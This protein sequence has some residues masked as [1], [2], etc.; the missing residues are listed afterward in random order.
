MI[1][2]SVIAAVAAKQ[3]E[4]VL[5]RAGGLP[6][7]EKLRAAPAGFAWIISGVRR[8]GKSTLMEQFL[9]QAPDEA[10]YLNLESTALAG[11][12]LEDAGRLD[13]AI[14]ATGAKTIYLDE[15]QTLAGWE[16]YV[17]TKLDEGFR[18]VAT[19]S[20]ASL[21]GRELGTKLTGRHV[22]TELFPFDYGEFL[23]FT[24]RTPGADATRA[25][26]AAGGFPSYLATDDERILETLFADILERDVALRHAV[27]DIAGLRRLAAWLVEN[28]GG[29]M[30]AQ[31]LRQPLGVASASTLLQWAEHLADAYLFS[32]LPKFSPSLR[33]QLVNPRKI[34]CIDTGLQCALSATNAPDESR[35]F[36]NL[37]FL[38]L[39]RRFRDL[40]YF[41]GDGR[42][43]DFVAVAG[44]RPLDPVQATVALNEDSEE[45]EV[46]GMR[47]AMAA[48]GR[49]RGWIVTVGEE[50]VLSVP[51]GEIRIVPFHAF[52]PAAI[53]EAAPVAKRENGSGT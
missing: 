28:A 3:K 1:R 48:L 45:R 43:C 4:H 11:L 12:S 18:V 46:T 9:R 26:L 29:K 24:E 41:E 33:V 36:E 31:R 27:R 22:D 15:V 8:C 53:G 32:F 10:F 23:A 16:R 37:V 17:R 21:L 7:L 25:Y 19:G 14:G 49:R 50:D 44:K 13:R 5:A 39:R 47:A 35:L 42:E 40:A 20:N 30:S 34:Y 52:D 6:R 51:E 2:E 38:A